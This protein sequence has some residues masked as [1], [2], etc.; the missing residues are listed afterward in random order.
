MKKRLIVLTLAFLTATVLFVALAMLFGS[1]L[2]TSFFKITDGW[3]FGI[4]FM[5]AFDVLKKVFA[6]DKFS[7]TYIVMMCLLFVNVATFSFA[8]TTTNHNFAIGGIAVSLFTGLCAI[9]LPFVVN[10]IQRN[11]DGDNTSCKSVDEKAI[12]EAWIRL[13]NRMRGMTDDRKKEVLREKL[14]FRLIGDNIYN[15]IDLT[16]PM[17]SCNGCCMTVK[18]GKENGADNDAILDAEKYID[19]LID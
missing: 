2:L 19:S 5:C 17:V 15:G 12:Q 3:I 9:L 16:R 4:L 18:A 11:R 13:S 7:K 14:A 1:S 6:K 8:S 10:Y